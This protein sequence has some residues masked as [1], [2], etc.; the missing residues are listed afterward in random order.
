[1]DEAR[2]WKNGGREIYSYGYGGA[3]WFDRTHSQITKAYQYGLVIGSRKQNA[4]CR[5][6]R[7][8]DGAKGVA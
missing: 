2:K 6:H 3:D 8:H 5:R 4:A 1:M 7:W